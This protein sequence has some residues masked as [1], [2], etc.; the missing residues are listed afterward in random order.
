MAED[1]RINREIV[2]E[3]DAQ[4]LHKMRKEGHARGFTVY[5]DEAERTGGENTA[6]PPLAY[7]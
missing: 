3:A 2:L 5:C 7:F 1:T 4:T 6:P